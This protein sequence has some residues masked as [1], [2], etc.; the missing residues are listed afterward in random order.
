MGTPWYVAPSLLFVA[1]LAQA[2]LFPSLGFLW[3]R[4]DLVL[5]IV[6]IWSL[7]RGLREALP[8]GFAGGLLLDVFS[9]APFG[10]AALALV[11]VAFCCSI[12]QV[13]AFRSNPLLPI[14]AVF[15]ASVLYSLIFL[16]LLRT[17]EVPVEWLSTLRLLVVPNAILNT[18]VAP[19]TYWLVSR[20]ER[21]TRSTVA[22]DW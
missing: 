7:L 17:H 12:G 19:L 11:L 8:W 22:V 20:I 14:V 4:P 9:G 21:R 10:T 18:V 6:V 16:F 13:S 5:Q 2:S 15:W 3:V 1:A